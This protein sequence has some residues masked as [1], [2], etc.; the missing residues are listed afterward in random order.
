MFRKTGYLMVVADCEHTKLWLNK[1]TVTPAPGVIPLLVLAHGAGAPADSQ[2]MTAMAE[3]LAC[4]GV[5]VVRFEF[6]YMARSREDGR[7]RPPN[8]MPLLLT[9]FRDVAATLARGHDGPVFLGG[10]SMGGRVASML[11]AD[12][13]TRVL[14]PELAGVVCLGYP[15]HPPGKPERLRTAHFPEL[16]L[17]QLIVQGPRDPFGRRDE[18]PHLFPRSAHGEPAGA[19]KVRVHWLADGDHDFR[20]LKRSG[21][22]LDDTLTEA[23]T[24]VA[25]FMRMTHDGH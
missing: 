9:H 14:I 7:K 23:A 1:A 20:P 5:H 3:A 18:M 10:K 22:V 12:P 2:W 19:D 15:F 25:R 17:P 24:E 4:C 8:P 16:Q 6:P 13:A 21:L 11:A